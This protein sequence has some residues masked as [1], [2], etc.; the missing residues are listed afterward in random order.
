MRGQ[1]DR[2][3]KKKKKERKGKTI[4]TR[5]HPEASS[6]STRKKQS[7]AID[8]SRDQSFRV[9]R[10]RDVG[11]RPRGG[12]EGRGSQEWPIEGGRERDR[13]G[14][15]AFDACHVHMSERTTTRHSFSVFLPLP[16]LSTSFPSSSL[17][18]VASI[19][20]PT[21]A[22]AFRAILSLDPKPNLIDIDSWKRLPDRQFLAQ[23]DCIKYICWI[24]EIEVSSI[25]D[26]V[27][28]SK[29]WGDIRFEINIYSNNWSFV[30]RNFNSAKDRMEEYK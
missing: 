30:R 17:H 19:F 24:L 9:F 15:H 7:A 14:R 26:R 12:G 18:P 8:R 5:C 13:G 1:F 21:I 20:F 11:R 25:I 16:P 4:N 23:H 22:H 10:S 29:I 27:L 3:L 6:C 2:A 28:E